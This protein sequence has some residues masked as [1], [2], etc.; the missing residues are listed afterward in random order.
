VANGFDV[1]FGARAGFGFQGVHPDVDVEGLFLILVPQPILK[2]WFGDL[3][4]RSDALDRPAAVAVAHQN[5]N[6][7]GLL[8]AR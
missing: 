1:L 3:G 2:G 6:A 5:S 8:K 4:S 7:V